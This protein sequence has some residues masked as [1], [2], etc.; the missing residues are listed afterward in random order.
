V[1]DE[2]LVRRV[3]ER[4]LAQ[5]GFAVTAAQ[6]AAEARQLADRQRP[7]VLVTDVVLPGGIDGITL[8]EGLR[9]RWPSLPVLLVSGY[10]ER[11]PPDWAPLLA[12]P[13]EPNQLAGAVAAVLRALPSASTDGAADRA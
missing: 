10:S 5:A 6:T 4:A 12:K 9:A 7:D 1:E 13:F 2:E 8:A 3:G 11:E